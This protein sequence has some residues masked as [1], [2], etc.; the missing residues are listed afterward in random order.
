MITQFFSLVKS[1]L[2]QI[3]SIRTQ[4]ILQEP[5]KLRKFHSLHGI[6]CLLGRRIELGVAGLLLFQT[7]DMGAELIRCLDDGI[8]MC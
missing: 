3:Q 6:P 2:V 5:I 7:L 8:K 4:T 1:Q